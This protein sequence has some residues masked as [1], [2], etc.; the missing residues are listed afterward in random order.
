MSNL[1]LTLLLIYIS[2]NSFIAGY[3]YADDFKFRNDRRGKL[4]SLTWIFLSLLFGTLIYG[5][6]IIYALI[7]RLLSFI[8]EFFQIRF[9]FTFYF[10][11]KWDNLEEDKVKEINDFANKKDKNKLK[12][13]IYI[14]CVNL[15]NKR[16]EKNKL[17]NK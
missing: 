12:D 3:N 16:L 10:T 17:K 1:L 14:Y 2:I 8:N 5:I 4:L 15:L 11:K 7:N 6:I 13:R 9:L